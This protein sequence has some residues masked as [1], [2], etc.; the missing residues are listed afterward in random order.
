[1]KL[2]SFL[3]SVS[4][5][6]PSYLTS[7][8]EPP[9]FIEWAPE[10]ALTLWKREPPPPSPA[11]NRNTV[12]LFSSP[13]PSHYTDCAI[14]NLSSSLSSSYSMSSHLTFCKMISCRNYSRLACHPIRDKCAAR[15]DLWDV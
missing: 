14:S 2:R 1:V 7:G 15:R 3:T 13:Q 11:R 9:V 6:L 8:K 5:S 12:P 4:F 10:S